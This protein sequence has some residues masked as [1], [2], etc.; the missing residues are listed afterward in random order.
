MGANNYISKFQSKFQNMAS[1]GKYVTL[2]KSLHPSVPQLYFTC[3]IR[4][5]TV[6]IPYGSFED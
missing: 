2:E 6:P 4:L 1:I 3:K 5:L